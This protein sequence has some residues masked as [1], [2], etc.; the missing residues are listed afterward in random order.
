M[1]HNPHKN[2]A[3]R[4]SSRLRSAMGLLLL[5]VYALGQ[6]VFASSALSQIAALTGQHQVLISGDCVVLHHANGEAS[7]HQGFTKFLVA[8]S[9]TNAAGD[10]ILPSVP[11]DLCEEPRQ[12]EDVENDLTTAF[13]DEQGG[14]FEHHSLLGITDRHE[15]AAA[16]PRNAFITQLTLSHWRT[17]KRVV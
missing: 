14:I 8:L 15:G 10:H 2:L 4:K 16:V 11:A 7:P 3:S 1:H 12:S 13:V 17:V 5:T 9:R 6:F